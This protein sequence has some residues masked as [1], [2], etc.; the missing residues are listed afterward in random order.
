MY[1]F[2]VMCLVSVIAAISTLWSVGVC[3]SARNKEE[4]KVWKIQKSIH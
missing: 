4:K 3:G 2:A 1:A